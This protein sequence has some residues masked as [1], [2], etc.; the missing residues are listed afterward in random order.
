MKYLLDYGHGGNDPGAI[1]ID[2][3]KEKDIV[4]EIGKRVKY[5]LERHGQIII[6]SRDSDK[7]VS[8]SERS[9]KANVNKVDLCISIHCNAFTQSSAQGFEIYHYD[10]ST[11]GEQLA[12]CILDNI[13]KANLYTKNRG[14]KTNNLHMTREVI[15]PSVLIELGFIT[16][17]SDK[18]LIVENKENFAI[19][20]TKGILK[21]WGIQYNENRDQQVP[22]VTN[23]KIYRVQVGAYKN[24]DNAIKLVEE[25]KSK[26]Y[27][28]III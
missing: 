8:L 28:A 26:G 17:A 24:K 25:L 5:H 21:Y 11:R 12:K 27:D 16:N 7:T 15:A 10:G 3:V 22:T 6:E 9:N 1:G 13:K 20:I 4:L 14:L 18:K 23:E 2:G 19:A